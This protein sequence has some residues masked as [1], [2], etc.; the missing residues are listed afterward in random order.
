MKPT[1]IEAFMREAILEGRNAIGA[2]VPNFPV[3]CV[4]VLDFII[5]AR[6]LTQS[7]GQGHSEAVVLRQLANNLKG[8]Y[9]LVTFDLVLFTDAR[10]PLLRLWS[11]VVREISS[12]AC[13]NQTHGIKVQ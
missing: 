3:G 2:C 12:Q 1:D 5:V 6:G 7:P 9:I 10:H 13:L 8:V 11:R 4:V